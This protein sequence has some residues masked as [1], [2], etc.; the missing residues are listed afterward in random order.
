MALISMAATSSHTKTDQHL[1]GPDYVPIG[2]K[3]SI[4]KTD[5][6]RG[7]AGETDEGKLKTSHGHAA[8]AR[9]GQFA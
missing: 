4:S 9:F 1:H 7:V 8:F 3:P 6:S 2:M 5:E